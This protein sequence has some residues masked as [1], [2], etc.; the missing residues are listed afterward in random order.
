MLALLALLGLTVSLRGES[1][2]LATPATTVGVYGQ[3]RE[4]VLPGPLLHVIPIAKEH[5]KL[6]LRIAAVYPHGTS[7]RY[8]FEYYGLEPGAYDLRDF[9]ACDPDAPAL[10]LPPIRVEVRSLLEPGQILP[11]A[12]SP[13]RL[14]RL[15]GYGV[16]AALALVTWLIGLILIIR[17]GRRKPGPLP[18]IATGTS[19]A[20]LLRPRLES[21]LAGQLTSQ[22]Y[23]ELE[24]ML[25]ELW[26]RR[27]GLQHMQTAEVW[28]V[29][30]Q[31][32]MAGPLLRQLEHWMHNPRRDPSANITDLLLP[33]LDFPAEETPP[34]LEVR[35]AMLSEPHA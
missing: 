19:L 16:L 8:D 1:P 6:V 21:A 33:Y 15:G 17:W 24:R 4:L 2:P 18:A 23:A 28:Q 31:H 12:L 34:G 27:L 35:P 22:Q 26:R 5:P 20:D 9:L 29:L 25:V 10:D 7:H 11:H 13:R 30:R 32:E 3:I 14:P